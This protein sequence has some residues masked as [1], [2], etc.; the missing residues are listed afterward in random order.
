MKNGRTSVWNSW[1]TRIELYFSSVF[2]GKT[3]P[4][5]CTAVKPIWYF[6]NS[7]RCVAKKWFRQIRCQTFLSE[8]TVAVRQYRGPVQKVIG[9][10]ILHGA[11][12]VIGIDR[13]KFK[14]SVVTIYYALIPHT[15]FII[16]LYTHNSFHGPK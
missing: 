14:Y 6:S 16:K 5:I 1:S 15:R 4:Q 11:H 12:D 3:S 9:R 13:V 10:R 2:R 7:P 8:S